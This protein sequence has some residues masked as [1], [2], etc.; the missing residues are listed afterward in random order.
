MTRI[1]SSPFTMWDDIYRTN[2]D[3]VR[4]AIDTFIEHLSGIKEH[5]G[6]QSLSGDFE[7]A[8]ITRGKIPTDS[9]GF[10][11]TLYEVL[12]VVEDK[13][14]VIAEIAGEF[15]KVNI[16]IKDIEVLKVREGEGGTLRLAFDREEEAEQAVEIL[17]RIHYTARIRR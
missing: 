7:V 13:P 17:T 3:A 4:E 8:N 5:I 12:V 14:G 16:N 1:A 15:A 11:K 2:N 6:S 10:M 9:K